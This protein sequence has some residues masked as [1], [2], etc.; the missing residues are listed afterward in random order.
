MIVSSDCCTMRLEDTDT[1]A[2][3]CCSMLDIFHNLITVLNIPIQEAM[4][5]LTENPAR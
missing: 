1:I 5:M 2:G 3:S 4:V